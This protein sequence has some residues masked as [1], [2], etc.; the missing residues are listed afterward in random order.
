M[1]KHEFQ[2]ETIRYNPAGSPRP[3]SSSVEGLEIKEKIV[4]K[5]LG[6]FMNNNMTSVNG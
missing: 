3:R 4:V 1:C 5:D 6:S 2:I